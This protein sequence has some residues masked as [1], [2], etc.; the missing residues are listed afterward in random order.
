MVLAHT[1]F[2]LGRTAEFDERSRNFAVAFGTTGIPNQVVHRVYGKRLNQRNVGACTGFAGAGARNTAPNHH[3][4]EQ[5]ETDAVGLA[6]YHR[7][8]ELDDIPGTWEPDG[9]G[10]DTGS[11][12]LAA[13][14]AMVEMGLFTRYEWCFGLQHLLV[15]LATRACMVGTNWY[16]GMFNPDARGIV[17]ISGAIAGG[18]EYV[19][20]GYNLKSQLLY[21]LNSWGSKWGIGGEFLM[22][23]ATADRLLKEDGDVKVPI[24]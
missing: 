7:A 8:T 4:G 10:E 20:R 11:S 13:C 3:I 17:T 24:L 2:P 1:P 9:S 5:A 22:P 6:V 21:G 12:G 14:K 19:F 18:H 15:G 23:F 16:E